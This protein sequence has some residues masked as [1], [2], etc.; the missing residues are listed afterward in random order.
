MVHIPFCFVV[1]A[2]RTVVY[3]DRMTV[4]EESYFREL[5]RCDYRVGWVT[6]ESGICREL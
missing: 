1:S 6:F 3:R 5:R 2:A 4:E